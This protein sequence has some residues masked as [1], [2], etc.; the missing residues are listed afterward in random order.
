MQHNDNS[1]TIQHQDKCSLP[2]HTK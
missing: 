1:D 2:K